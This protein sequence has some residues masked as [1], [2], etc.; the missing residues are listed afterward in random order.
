LGNDIDGEAAGDSSGDSVALSDNGTIVAIGAIYNDGTN[1]LVSGNNRGSVRVYQLISNVWTQLGGDIDGEAALD[2]YGYSVSLSS[3]GSVVA[4]GANLNDGTSGTSLADRGHVRVYLRDTFN[5]TIAPIGWT[6]LGSDIDGE[7]IGDQSGFSVALSRDGL[8][9]AIGAINNDGT[10]GLSTDNRGHVRIYKREPING[11]Y[12]NAPMITS[13]MQTTSYATVGGI[14]GVTGAT[15][16][17]STLSIVGATTMTSMTSSSNATIG[18]TLTIN[19]ATTLSSTLNI[20]G[21]TT[22]SALTT[23]SNATV[24]GVLNVTGATTL[25]ALN[26]TDRI[27][28]W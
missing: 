28:Q 20:T 23:I 27:M 3:D 12:I 6:Q 7:A 2:Y 9:V 24:G 21:A 13:N 17:N 15:I 1:P 26:Y 22:T 25:T 10:T 5:T 18:G 8:S 19:G 16:S 4:I 11:L 14:L